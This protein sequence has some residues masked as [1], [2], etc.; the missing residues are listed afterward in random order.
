[1][2]DDS[3]LAGLIGPELTPAY[4]FDAEE[5]VSRAESIKRYIRECSEEY[6]PGLCFSVKANPFLVPVLKDTVDYFE[7][8]SPGELAICRHHE[9]P[10]EKIIYSGVQKES[11]DIGDAVLYPVSVITAES[12]RQY[13][14]ICQVT[15]MLQKRTEVILRM[16]SKSQFGMSLEDI[17]AILQV[18][19]R[20]PDAVISGI[21]YFAGT[22]REKLKHREEELKELKET[23]LFLRRQYDIPL[24]R[25]EYGPGLPYPYF[26]GDDFSDTLQPLKELLPALTDIAGECI[27]T[28]EMGRFLASSCGYYLTSVC[29]VKSSFGRNWCIVDGGIHHLNYLGQMMGMKLP[30][31]R[32]FR[33]GENGFDSVLPGDGPGQSW[34]L[35]GSLC[36]TNDVL[37]RSID[38]QKPAHGD[39]F[40]FCHCGAYSVTEAIALF[41]SRDMPKIFLYQEGELRLIRDK[42]ESWRM[43]C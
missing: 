42:V 10:G 25:F 43:N 7:V 29:D 27:L 33:R 23:F 9:I 6:P 41:L 15:T 31:L 26:Q 37:I 17:G 39:V 4:I 2:I 24:R 16:S 34:A 32:H 3:K 12:V 20:H 35:C 22:Q 18:R 36:T 13:E 38:L 5:A 1:M 40:V 21:H 28:V 30:V 8:C 14:L 19:G 11:E